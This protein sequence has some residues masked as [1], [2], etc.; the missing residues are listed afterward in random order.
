MICSSDHFCPLTITFSLYSVIHKLV[1]YITRCFPLPL[2][3]SEYIVRIKFS[4]FFFLIMCSRKFSSHFLVLSESV[5][6]LFPFSIKLN[7]LLIFFVHGI[8]SIFLLNRISVE[9]SSAL[10]ICKWWRGH[11]LPFKRIG[12]T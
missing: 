1:R 3:P 11:P 7:S 5:F 12:M 8:V 4:K 6:F 9:I 2:L 10:F